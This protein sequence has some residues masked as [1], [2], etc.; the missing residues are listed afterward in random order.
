MSYDRTHTRIRAA[1]LKAFVEGSPCPFCHEPMWSRQKLDLAHADDETGRAIPGQY[2]GLSH[3]RCNQ[4]SAR[5]V[6]PWGHK[7][8]D[9]EAI[10]K[11]SP[12]RKQ[13]LAE[14][15]ARRQRKDFRSEFERAQEDG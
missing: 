4:R 14:K 12:A 5:M 3:A 2:R 8:R 1:L 10:A 13:E 6:N 7:T 9:P 11:R 15:A